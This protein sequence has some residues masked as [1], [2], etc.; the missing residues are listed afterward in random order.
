VIKCLH[1][2]GTPEKGKKK[3]TPTLY[4]VISPK[5]VIEI[6]AFFGGWGGEGDGLIE[7]ET[8]QYTVLFYRNLNSTVVQYTSQPLLMT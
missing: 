2:V 4:H 6:A 7:M 5:Y 3:P 1:R 8:I